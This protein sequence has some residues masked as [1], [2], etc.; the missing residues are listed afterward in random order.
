MLDLAKH[1]SNGFIQL[2][3][4]ASREGISMK[5]LEQIVIPLKK[6]GYVKSV[7]GAGGGYR[8]SKPPEEIRVGEIVALLEGGINIIDCSTSPES[9]ER[10]E[11]CVTRELWT[12]TAKAMYEKLNAVTLYDLLASG[13]RV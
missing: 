8:L 9:C 13:K 7:R 12:E 4:I 2:R 1:F 5:Y 11:A 3:D 10:S 6:A